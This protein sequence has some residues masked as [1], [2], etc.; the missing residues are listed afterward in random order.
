[1]SGP[2]SDIDFEG[3]T[4]EDVLRWLY[5]SHRRVAL[6]ASFQAESGV[7]IDMASRLVKRPEV[8]TL[9]TGRLPEETYAVMDEFRK[10]YDVE[11]RILAP[12][13]AEVERMTARHGP[14]LFRT[15]VGLRHECCEIRKGRP[16]A[17]ALRDHDAWIT[18]VRRRQSAERGLIP[19]VS[20]DPV[21]GGITKVAPLARWSRDD[22]W[23]Y[24]D[25][26][27]LPRNALYECGYT[28][29]GCAPCT[30]STRPGEEE[31]AG[32]WW[33]EGGSVKECG[34]HQPMVEVA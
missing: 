11:L 31:R 17:R 4:A 16:L 28:S 9:D 23:R 30:R 3:A 14:N 10:R 24:L 6:V 20:R 21:H 25:E 26:R 15:S 29:I 33:W 22:V 32:R 2:V 13:A 12:E 7:L 5:G 1:M 18:G 27:S 34:L 8:L 19:V